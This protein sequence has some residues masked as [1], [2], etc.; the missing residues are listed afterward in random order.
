MLLNY[1]DDPQVLT[2][3]AANS[4]RQGGSVLV[5]L[6][7]ASVTAAHLAHDVLRALGVSAEDLDEQHVEEQQLP[8]LVTYR[9]CGLRTRALVLDCP[10]P[11]SAAALRRA[12]RWCDHLRAQLVLV[13]TTADWVPQPWLRTTPARL[14]GLAPVTPGR[15][16]VSDADRSV[17]ELATLPALPDDEFTT[18]RAACRRLPEQH[19]ATFAGEYL[20]AARTIEWALRRRSDDKRTIAALT[21]LYALLTDEAP[22]GP[23]RIIRVRAAQAALF[24]HGRVLVRWTPLTAPHEHATSVPETLLPRHCLPALRQTA[25]PLLAARITL[26]GLLDMPADH[27]LGLRRDQ[28]VLDGYSD[29]VLGFAYPPAVAGTHA[30]VQLPDWTLPVLGAYRCARDHHD[31]YGIADT[32]MLLPKQTQALHIRSRYLDQRLA[33]VLRQLLDPGW[34]TTPHADI[35]DSWLSRRHLSITALPRVPTAVP[36]PDTAP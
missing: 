5:R 33:D 31:I 11:L 20:A 22:P 25:D 19:W 34:P 15:R 17:A 6:S 36:T 9:L 18:F 28:L 29:T 21:A 2:R 27:L 7:P 30:V 1:G 23:A 4:G 10:H 8:D 35:L 24:T 32:D 3:L 14:E 16:A 26:G 13:V 12:Q